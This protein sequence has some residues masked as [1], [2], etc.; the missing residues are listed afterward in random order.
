[1]KL[2]KDKKLNI[3]TILSFVILFAYAISLVIPLI[4]AFITSCRTDIDLMI[5]GGMKLPSKWVNNYSKVLK[6]FKV[7]I[8]YNGATRPVK[9]P[10]MAIYSILYALGGAIFSAL[11]SL[12]MAYV[13]SRFNFKFCK[14]IYV[15]VIIQMIIPIVGS[16][17]SEIR[18]ARM[19]KVYDKVIGMWIMKTYVTGLY[20]LLFYG[21][22][23]LIPNEY[24]EAAQ[25]DG[26]SN[27]CVMTRIIFPFIS[28]SIFTVV[29]LL[30]ISLWNDYQTPFIY[31]PTHPTLAYGL[32]N[33]VNG[34]YEIETS[35]TP[36]KLAGCM[37]MA[38]PLLTVFIVFQKRLLGDLSVGGL[39]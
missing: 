13:S 14:T 37:L 9:I 26:A 11:A 30:F 22:L 12:L 1:M 18:V 28:G 16:L 2:F 4:W 6:Y 19:L 32:Y 20:F 5:N 34:S 7:P 24:V 31:M 23:K 8:P 35:N 17:P 3:F 29:L 39:K 25:I 27:F 10:E 15:I 38:V 21:S 33:Y 36:L